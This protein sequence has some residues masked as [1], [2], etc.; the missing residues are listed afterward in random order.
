MAK[1][2]V[3][4]K[5]GSAEVHPA[6]MR[7]APPPVDR[8]P[9]C[10]LCVHYYRHDLKKKRRREPQSCHE[11]NCEP[12]DHCKL[13]Q[14]LLDPLTQAQVVAVQR[15]G[16]RPLDLL[17]ALILDRRKQVKDYMKRRI[18]ELQK[19]GKVWVRWL[20]A[21]S[22]KSLAARV[23]R[24]SAAAVMLKPRTDGTEVPEKIKVL[25]VLEF[26]THK[27]YQAQK[28]GQVTEREPPT[29]RRPPKVKS[30]K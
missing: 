18:R 2:K 12:H 11:L 5:E 29:T 14:R 4:L 23:L 26:L 15:M 19:D 6:K 16:A 13:F 21:E 9:R 20:D 1:A 30:K 7:K 3:D 10:E 22:G 17:E 25:D 24:V 8:T 28:E 27:E